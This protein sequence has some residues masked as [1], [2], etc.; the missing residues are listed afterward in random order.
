[1]ILVGIGSNLPYN[2]RSSREI[3]DLV[4]RLLADRGVSVAERSSTYTTRPVGPQNQ[5]PFVNA[6]LALRFPG[7]P[8]ALLARLHDVEAAMGR[9]R[10]GKWGPRTL[11][12]DL[13][14][15][16]G[17]RTGAPDA[18]CLTLHRRPLMLPHPELAHRAF[19]LVPL[20]EIAPDWRHPVSHRRARDLLRALAP[21]DR[22][23][24]RLLDV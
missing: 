6:V 3:V 12:L 11:D 15:F 19:V 7:T 10:A 9:K 21:E 16:N 17:R 18:A 24:V 13:L 20:V 1:M 23:G 22:A 14:D 8:R 5:P 4:P 2:E